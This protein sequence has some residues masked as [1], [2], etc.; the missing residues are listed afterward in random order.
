MDMVVNT[1][2]C[3]SVFGVQPPHRCV[4]NSRLGMCSK[5]DIIL[6]KISVKHCYK[7]GFSKP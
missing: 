7:N 1:E 2:F 6:R 5:K 4:A 3:G